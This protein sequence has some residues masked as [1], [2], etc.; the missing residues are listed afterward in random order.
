MVREEQQEIAFNGAKNS[1]EVEQPSPLQEESPYYL[2]PASDLNTGNRTQPGEPGSLD[3]DRADIYNDKKAG[4]DAGIKL[5]DVTPQASKAS[6]APYFG[7]EHPYRGEGIRR[8]LEP[9]VHNV[10]PHETL[11]QISR[12]HLGPNSSRADTANYAREILAVNNFKSE[13]E[14]RSIDWI[15]LPGH[16]PDGSIVTKSLQTTVRRTVSPTGS[17]IAEDR[18]HGYTRIGNTEG[19][20]SEKH[21]GERPEDNFSINRTNDGDYIVLDEGGRLNFEMRAGEELTE[22][23]RLLRRLAEANEPDLERLSKFRA[24]MVRFESRAQERNLGAQEVI[25]TYKQIGR[26]LSAGTAEPTTKEERLAIAGQVLSQ[27]ANP[28]T[29]DQGKHPTCSLASV[30]VRNYTRHPAAVAKLV[31]D[32]AIT[33]RYSATDAT[34]ITIDQ[35]SMKPD[36]FGYQAKPL[37]RGM[38]SQASQIFTVTA[39]NWI[40]AKTQPDKQYVQRRQ[41]Y[42]TPEGVGEDYIVSKSNPA[43]KRDFEGFGGDDAVRLNN[44][45]AGRQEKNVYLTNQATELGTQITSLEQLKAVLT[46]IGSDGGPPIMSVFTL[47][48][49]FWSDSGGRYS[50]GRHALT[51]TGYSPGAGEVK[52]DNQWGVGADHNDTPIKVEDLYLALLGPRAAAKRVEAQM[53]EERSQSGTTLDKEFDLLRLMSMTWAD[54]ELID[55]QIKLS[56]ERFEKEGEK[57]MPPKW[58]DSLHHA[59]SSASPGTELAVLSKAKDREIFSDDQLKTTWASTFS[60]IV[61]SRYSSNHP[62]EYEK[63]IGDMTALMAVLPEKQKAAAVGGLQQAIAGINPGDAFELL[64]D[65]QAKNIIDKKELAA[66]GAV[67]SARHEALAKEL[68]H[69]DEPRNQLL[70]SEAANQKSR[71]YSL[72]RVD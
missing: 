61:I 46:E 33:G 42:N 54:Q 13:S 58:R 52:V 20:Y 41:T 55:E 11:E 35:E 21:Y 43:E 67:A 25:A 51:I 6:E 28:T 14:I 32:A 29:I 31:A 57:S 38:R 47:T 71:F 17:E 2:R 56:F 12:R 39:A 34:T 50:Q 40:L 27:A 59:L 3:F 66:L 60:G 22:Q 49:P 45:L 64:A 68:L 63:N 72:L 16:K 65:I 5:P 4:I 48:E 18:R 15:L 10:K 36:E 44:M 1:T 9:Q 23:R 70:L 37:T 69:S 53:K 24:D 62:D 26:L 7:S 8:E 19:G 30:E